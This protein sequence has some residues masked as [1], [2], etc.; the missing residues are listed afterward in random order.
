MIAYHINGENGNGEARN[1]QH[2]PI[3][4]MLLIGVFASR[5]WTAVIAVVMCLLRVRSLCAVLKL[6]FWFYF[7]GWG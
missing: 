6:Q 5:C 2:Y 1:W 4:V 7:A 3:I